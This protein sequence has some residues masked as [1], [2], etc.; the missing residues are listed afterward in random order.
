MHRMTLL[1]INGFK[2][3][4]LILSQQDWASKLTMFDMSDCSSN[5]PAWCRSRRTSSM[6]RTSSRSTAA[7]LRWSTLSTVTDQF[8]RGRQN[9]SL[10][11]E[12]ATRR[13]WVL[14][15]CVQPEY[16]I[17]CK[18]SAEDFQKWDH[19]LTSRD[20]GV[21]SALWKALKATCLNTI[22][23]RNCFNWTKGQLEMKRSLPLKAEFVFYIKFTLHCS[24]P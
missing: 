6:R 9:S 19:N 18:R 5:C 4:L 17:R 24:L 12:T 15:F 23:F 20:V 10:D 1:T 2:N 8:T 21:W 13:S 14:T 3:Q 11:A 16:L 7:R 22:L